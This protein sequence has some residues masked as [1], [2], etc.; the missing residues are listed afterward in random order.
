[1]WRGRWMHRVSWHTY[2]LAHL[3]IKRRIIHLLNIGSGEVPLKF[4]HPKA[5]RASIPL[6]ASEESL[7]TSRQTKKAGA[8]RSSP[9]KACTPLGTPRK[10]ELKTLSDNRIFPVFFFL[11][12]SIFSILKLLK[13]SLNFYRRL[14]NF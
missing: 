8:S 6:C 10:H 4:V 2:K 11:V 7:Y 5:D 12:F 9:T 3:K 1:M 13:S 14:F